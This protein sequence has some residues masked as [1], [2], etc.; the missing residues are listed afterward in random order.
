[1]LS[2]RERS[3]LRDMLHHIELAERFVQGFNLESFGRDELHLRGNAMFGNHFRS[4]SPL[5]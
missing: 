2:D 1:M 4:F 3:V 5:A